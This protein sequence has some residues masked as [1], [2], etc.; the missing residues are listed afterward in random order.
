MRE[1][2]QQVPAALARPAH[3]AFASPKSNLPRMTLVAPCIAQLCALA[4]Q[5][6]IACAVSHRLL[7]SRQQLC[8]AG[9]VYE[10]GGGGGR[11]RRAAAAGGDGRASHA[12]RRRRRR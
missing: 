10:G 1:L 3:T 11:C 5:A 12:A 6:F 8:F 2:S 9:H 4:A 7:S